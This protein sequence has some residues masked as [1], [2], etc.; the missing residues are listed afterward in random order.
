MNVPKHDG[1][2]Y[3]K[4]KKSYTHSLE[5]FAQVVMLTKNTS[6]C[7]LYLSWENDQLCL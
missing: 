2:L 6:Y 4:N 1:I 7:L 3:R 5:L